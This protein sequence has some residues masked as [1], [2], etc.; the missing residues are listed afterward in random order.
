[1]TSGTAPKTTMPSKI[2][3]VPALEP[4]EV[5]VVPFPFSDI[6][7]TKR[8]PA[9]VVSD[10]NRFNAPARHTVLAMITTA[11]AAIWT[12]DVLIEHPE[13]GG[14]PGIPSVRMKLFTLDNRLIVKSLGHL[15]E[16]DRRKVGEH[17]NVLIAY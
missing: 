1:W 16:S 13:R 6:A 10:H 8:R 17:L 4:F 9:L 7:R 15:S 14:L 5:V 3:D 12:L 2:S 11:K